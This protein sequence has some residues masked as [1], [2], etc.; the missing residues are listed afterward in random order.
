[1]KNYASIPWNQLVREKQTTASG[2]KEKGKLEKSQKY[3][4]REVNGVW[5]LLCFTVQV[6]QELCLQTEKVDMSIQ[7][8][9]LNYIQDYVETR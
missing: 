4:E 6:T 1:M 7:D 2:H 8:V 9:Q 5:L 3:W